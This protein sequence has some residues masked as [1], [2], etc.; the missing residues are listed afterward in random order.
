[1]INVKSYIVR[2]LTDR[3]Y[4]LRYN[5]EKTR[6][7]EALWEIPEGITYNSYV[8]FGDEKTVLFDGWKKGLEEHFIDALTSILDPKDIDIIV[9]NHL[10]PDHS[11]TVPA[12]LNLN[13][14]AQVV[15]HPLAKRMFSSF[16]GIKDRVRGVRDG[17]RIPLGNTA[18]SLHYVPWLHWPETIVS[19]IEGDKTLL[20]CDVFGG[21]SIPP[22]VDDEDD[23][24][25]EK[26]LP[27]AKKYVFTVIGNY[28]DYIV[29]NIEK[30]KTRGIDPSIIA[31]AHGLV[32]RRKPEKI[33]EYYM[34]L[35]SGATKR[36]KIVV[37]YDSMYGFID[38]FMEEAVSLLGENGAR[39][40]VF[41]A[42]D[43]ERFQVGDLIG[44]VGDSEIIL[45]GVSTY[46]AGVFPF[47]N[48][49]VDLL[50]HKVK[51]R[52]KFLIVSSYGWGGVAARKI[53][54]KLEAGGQEV[55]G[56]IEFGGKHS[57]EEIE[58]LVNILGIERSS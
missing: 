24:V 19:Y 42:T 39:P 21:Y 34:E 11:G 54:E 46:E 52:K 26:Y 56:V 4:I 49:V 20:S 15:G 51:R 44:E 32:F 57:L 35:A 53:R 23:E 27:Y 25:V 14:R 30:L 18:M 58:K 28:I 10:E 13:R 31:P 40:V 7:F 33:I 47:M 8:Y 16:Y 5:D 41:R 36:G 38:A 48:Y 45:L 6:Y 37:V 29:K 43:S 3:L 55:I 17:E 12:V 9:S 1:M 22:T 50:V 2:K